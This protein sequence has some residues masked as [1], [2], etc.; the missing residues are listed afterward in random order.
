M[1]EARLESIAEADSRARCAV[2]RRPV[3]LRRDGAIRVHGPL[4]HRCAG[5]GEPPSTVIQD[6]GTV[7]HPPS[8]A[9]ATQTPTP[10]A[11][12]AGPARPQRIPI[13]KRLPRASQDPAA[14]K[15]AA[16]LEQVTAAN[17]ADAWMRLM[18]FEDAILL[19]SPIGGSTSVDAAIISRVE[20]LKV[21][22]K[23]LAHFQK[24]DALI[25]LRHSFAIP[26]I[27]YILRTA[28]CFSSPCLE[29]F[30][31]ELRSM[32]GAILNISLVDASSWSQATL[33]VGSG[34][35]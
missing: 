4:E 23:R 15:L 1:S 3:A 17:D 18:N 2:C 33:P 31:Q 26:K 35:S 8:Q 25:L 11:V 32:M 30:D 29:S 10:P 34:G 9:P 28:P 7:G 16:I 21:M 20:A 19:G 6:T 14:R 13:L 5:S 22:G 12:T 27:L 24:H